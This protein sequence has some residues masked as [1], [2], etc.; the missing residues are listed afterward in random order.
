MLIGIVVVRAV[1]GAGRSG[2]WGL[3]LGLGRRIDSLGCYLRM[4]R[5]K[6]ESRCQRNWRKVWDLGW[7]S[8]V[9]VVE[10]FV[11]IVVEFGEKDL[12]AVMVLVV[13]SSAAVGARGSSDLDPWLPG[14]TAQARADSKEI[15]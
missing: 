11:D 13:D 1:V 15:R 7:V 5:R 8:V 2:V 4:R 10:G 6:V 9:V 12:V 3:R 14:K